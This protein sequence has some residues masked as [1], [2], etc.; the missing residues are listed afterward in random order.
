[1]DS[2]TIFILWNIIIIIFFILIGTLYYLKAL[3]QKLFKSFLI[4]FIII[5]SQGLIYISVN[6]LI[7]NWKMG[8]IY[9]ENPKLKNNIWD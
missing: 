7:I 4:I 2:L 5:W 3:N 1:M 9:L 6:Y 8:E